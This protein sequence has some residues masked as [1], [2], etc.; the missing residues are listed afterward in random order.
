MDH[1]ADF[2]KEF[3]AIPSFCLGWGEA[4]RQQKAACWPVRTYQMPVLT[5]F[6]CC[7]SLPS[8]R[9]SEDSLAAASYSQRYEGESAQWRVRKTTPAHNSREDHGCCSFPP[10]G[11]LLS[12]HCGPVWGAAVCSVY[13]VALQGSLGNSFAAVAHVASAGQTF[14]QAETRLLETA[15][16]ILAFSPGA[17]ELGKQWPFHS[18]TLTALP[19]LSPVLVTGEWITLFIS[20][21]TGKEV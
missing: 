18:L 6:V 10:L 14:A 3:G 7:T 12:A 9:A 15:C 13:D 21:I 4:L 8:A 5:A 2:S 20:R 17:R 19:L 1:L 11:A 16:I